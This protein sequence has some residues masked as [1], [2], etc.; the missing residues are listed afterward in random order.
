MSEIPETPKSYSI[1]FNLLELDL[2]LAVLYNQT[3]MSEQK[4]IHIITKIY[5]SSPTENLWGKRNSYYQYH[6][7]KLDLDFLKLERSMA[8]ENN[9]SYAI[10]FSP[11]ELDQILRVLYVQ[12]TIE[13]KDAIQMIAKIN[14]AVHQE[15]TISPNHQNLLVNQNLNLSIINATEVYNRYHRNY[16]S[17]YAYGTNTVTPNSPNSQSYPI[18]PVSNLLEA[19]GSTLQQMSQ[20]LENIASHLSHSPKLGFSEPVTIYCELYQ[21]HYWYQKNAEQQK[22][23]IRAKQLGFMLK[24]VEVRYRQGKPKVIF[25]AEGDKLYHLESL[26]SSLFTTTFLA[27][28]NSLSPHQLQRALILEPLEDPETFELTCQLYQD[29]ALISLRGSL[30]LPWANL[31]QQIQ[32]KLKV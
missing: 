17:Y 23:P 1:T 15:S 24:G 2:L 3:V 7:N 8:G 20:T 4:A 19:I 22:V 25:L 13:D 27:L 18:S 29:G 5:Q 32:D 9:I 16:D 31:V 28:V 12:T 10:V 6:T 30:P 21:G 11:I 14:M 26:A